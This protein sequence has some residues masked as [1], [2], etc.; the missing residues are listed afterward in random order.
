MLFCGPDQRI[1]SLIERQQFLRMAPGLGH[2]SRIV[3]GQR[4][5]CGKGYGKMFVI[6]REFASS[7]LLGEIQSAEDRIAQENRGAQKCPH[8][9]M[10]FGKSDRGRMH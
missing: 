1:G 5:G 3:N 7:F 4:C 10:S 8:G 9:R 6:R 2:H